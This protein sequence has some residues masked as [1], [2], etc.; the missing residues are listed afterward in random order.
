MEL[1][2][3]FRRVSTILVG[4]SQVLINT[5]LQELFVPLAKRMGLEDSPSDTADE[6]Q[7]RTTAVEQAASA[8]DQW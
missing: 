4:F 5:G 3:A 7:L 8:G 2:N 6:Q 1:L